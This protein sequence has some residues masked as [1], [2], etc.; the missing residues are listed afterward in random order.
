MRKCK[1]VDLRSGLVGDHSRGAA[2]H[3]IWHMIRDYPIWGDFYL[4]LG[5][6]MYTHLNGGL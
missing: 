1:P 3:K 5:L 2:M 4:Q 6:I